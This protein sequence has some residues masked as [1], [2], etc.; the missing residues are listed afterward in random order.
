VSIK[1]RSDYCKYETEESRSNKTK[2]GQDGDCWICQRSE[3]SGCLP[4]AN[5]LQT[6]SS[7]F[8]PQYA[9]QW[10]SMLINLCDIHYSLTRLTR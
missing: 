4:S 3:L 10:I 8:H 6:D 9:V 5:Q 1:Q 2:N 7:L